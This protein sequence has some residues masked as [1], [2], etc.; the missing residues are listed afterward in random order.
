MCIQESDVIQILVLKDTS[1]RP[2]TAFTFIRGTGD[3]ESVI[4]DRA[5]LQIPITTLQ[6]LPL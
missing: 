5:S 1:E 3:M 6:S 2:K 4:P